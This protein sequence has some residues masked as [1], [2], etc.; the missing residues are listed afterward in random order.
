MVVLLVLHNNVATTNKELYKGAGK[1][2][3]YISLDILV[4]LSL[5]YKLYQF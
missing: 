1:I 5:C 4:Q 3:M 2:D